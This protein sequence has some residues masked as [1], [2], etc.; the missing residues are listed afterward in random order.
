MGNQ[1]CI[2][3]EFIYSYT[4]IL[5]FKFQIFV[6]FAQVLLGLHFP[7]V[8][9]VLRLEPDIDALLAPQ[10][11]SKQIDRLDLIILALMELET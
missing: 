2:E 10:L 5:L 11:N 3:S 8:A 7:V 1:Q 9:E 6:I 4:F